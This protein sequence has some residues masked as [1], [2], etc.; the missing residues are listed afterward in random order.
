MASKRCPLNPTRSRSRY[1]S[2]QANGRITAFAPQCSALCANCRQFEK[3]WGRRNSSSGDDS[4]N[5]LSAEKSVLDGLK[6]FDWSTTS[7]RKVKSNYAN[8]Y[9]VACSRW[10]R[11]EQSVPISRT[12]G[13]RT[14]RQPLSVP[15]PAESRR[16]VARRR[17]LL[18]K[19]G[20][21]RGRNRYAQLVDRIESSRKANLQ[22]K[23]TEKLRIKWRINFVE[24]T[25]RT[26][27]SI[28]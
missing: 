16:G 25:I 28:S 24:G 1:F 20:S 6:H 10:N 21:V 2:Y 13:V 12:A 5:G 15:L 27:Y 26:R 8:M 17:R 7:A 4:E 3:Q 18:L 11:F 14:K 19:F 23:P 9:I 22:Q